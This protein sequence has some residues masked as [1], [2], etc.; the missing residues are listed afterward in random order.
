M[1]QEGY[2]KVIPAMT[3]WTFEEIGGLRDLANACFPSP[4]TYLTALETSRCSGTDHMHLHADYGWAG[5]L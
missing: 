5:S 3:K 1:H 2:A 4:F